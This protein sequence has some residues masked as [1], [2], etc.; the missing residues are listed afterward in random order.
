[1]LLPEISGWLATILFNISYVPQ[2]IKTFRTKKVEDISL[3]LWLSLVG[4]YVT[5]AIYTFSIK[6]WP[7]LVGHCTGFILVFIYLVLYFKYR[8]GSNV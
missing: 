6:A 1:M 3:G 2:I 4:A 5:G 7:I 8:R